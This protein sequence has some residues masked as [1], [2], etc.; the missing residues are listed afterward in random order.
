MSLKQ[1]NT[2]LGVLSYEVTGVI[3]RIPIERRG[4]SKRGN[5][6]VLG[7]L[8]IEV[9]EDGKEGSAQLYLETWEEEMIERINN[10]GIGKN[11]RVTFHIESREW[12]DKF[13][14][15]IIIDAIGG[16]TE[17]EDYLYSKK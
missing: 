14:T 11:V 12:Y 9:R 3:R 2:G 5:E 6:W 13:R 4:V 15:S 1:D 16:L 7:G 17:N 8:M 10:I